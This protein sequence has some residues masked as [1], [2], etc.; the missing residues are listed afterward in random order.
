MKRFFLA[1]GLVAGLVA[2]AAVPWA[3]VAQAQGDVVAQRKEGMKRMGA[4]LEAVKA[5]VESSGPAAPLAPRA[6]EMRAFFAGL[7]ALFP[8]GSTAESKARPEVWSE[9]AGFERAA[10]TAT[11]AATKIAAAATADDGA[12]V[13]AAFREVA[14]SCGGCHRNYRAR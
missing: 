1:C 4:H 11:E 13:A 2:L 7:P 3:G 12:A 9:R 10:A 8:A 6:E 5:V 14:S